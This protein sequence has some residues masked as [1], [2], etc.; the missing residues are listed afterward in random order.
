MTHVLTV[1]IAG[2]PTS[3]RHILCLTFCKDLLQGKL[4]QNFLS[5]VILSHI[6][7][8]IP[9]SYTS[10][11]YLIPTPNLWLKKKVPLLT[12][13][14]RDIIYQGITSSICRVIPIILTKSCYHCLSRHV[15]PRDNP[16]QIK[17][18]LLVL[19]FHQLP[20]S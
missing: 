18:T 20:S 8:L 5:S 16:A 1:M 17:Y 19:M 11:M 6:L 3:D 12:T 7:I 14:A 15:R 4:C 10:F 13:V 2:C 9:H